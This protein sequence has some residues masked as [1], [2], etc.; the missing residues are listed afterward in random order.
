MLEHPWLS[1]APD[2]QLFSAQSHA[3]FKRRV[4]RLVAIRRI[5]ITEEDQM[6]M[7]FEA[8]AKAA[9]VADAVAAVAAATEVARQ[10]PRS[11]RGRQA[12]PS[13]LAVANLRREASES[14]TGS[15]P[16]GLSPKAAAAVKASKARRAALMRQ[17]QQK[18]QQQVPSPRHQQ[19][20][21]P[22][23]SVRGQPVVSTRL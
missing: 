9:A 14:S 7:K 20:P 12:P 2:R 8:D 21:I 17:Q 19:S 13:H 5:S 3:E 10:S 6:K 4:H 16:R 1:E 11:M 22:L 18:Q 23:G 15:S